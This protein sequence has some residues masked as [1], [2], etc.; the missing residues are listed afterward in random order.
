MW[1]RFADADREKL[2]LEQEWIELELGSV[3]LAEAMALE[4]AGGDWTKLDDPGPA[5]FACRAW[6]ALYRAG[7]KETIEGI[8][9]LDVMGFQ[10]RRGEGKD[11]ASPEG[12]E[13]TQPT[14][15][16]SSE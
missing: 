6:M 10:T 7:V 16:T 12:S 14:S 9:F 1:Y 3:T 15:P 5:G 13:D 11:E 2:G 4:A 8:G